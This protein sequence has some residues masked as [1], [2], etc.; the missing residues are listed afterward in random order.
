VKRTDSLISPESLYAEGVRQFQPS[1]S[2]LGNEYVER[3]AY[4]EGVGQRLRRKGTNFV[5]PG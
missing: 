1:V 4:T 2:T 3:V 5:D